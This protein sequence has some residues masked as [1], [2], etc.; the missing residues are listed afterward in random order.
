MKKWLCKTTPESSWLNEIS[1]TLLRISA[2][3]LMAFLHGIGKVPPSEKFIGGVTALGF[4]APELFAW[5][6]GLT[7]LVGG[8]LLAIGFLTRPTA[9][10]FSFTMFVAAFGVHLNDPWGDKELSLIYLVIGLVFVTRG[11]GK[12]SVDHLIK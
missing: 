1:L 3:L 6:A 12:I 11:S 7:E 2:G 9:L 5:A 8:I 10:L 4:P